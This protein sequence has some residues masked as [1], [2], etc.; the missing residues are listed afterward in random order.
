[1]PNTDIW[2]FDLKIEKQTAQLSNPVNI[3]SNRGY[4]NQPYFSVDGKKILF[5]RDFAG[6][7][8]I[9]EHDVSSGMNKKRTNTETSEYSPQYRNKDLLVLMVEK[10][11]SQRIWSNPG[12]RSAKR[13]T[14]I[15]GEQIGYYLFL[16]SNDVMTFILGEPPLLK[17]WDLKKGTSKV[18][19]DSIGRCIKF[20]PGSKVVSFTRIMEGRVWLYSYDPESGTKKKLKELPSED[21]EWID[22][23]S[24]VSADGN[25]IKFSTLE[26]ESRWNNVQL[27]ERIS[28]NGITRIAYSQATGK[29]AV[30]AKE[31]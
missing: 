11:S 14:N 22:K 16:S 31:E 12:E 3:T 17:R 18:I 24:L 20:I 10:D 7:T 25:T 27:L 2:L 15:K 21:Y 6:Q 30:V 19:S 13:I 28:L 8:D 5:S 26:P 9:M 1:M 4:D 29:L 23:S